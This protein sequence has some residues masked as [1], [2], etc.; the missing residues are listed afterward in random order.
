MS[1]QAAAVRQTGS[2]LLTE[3]DE[4]AVNLD[5]WQR[6]LQRDTEAVIALRQQLDGRTLQRQGFSISH[7][8]VLVTVRELEAAGIIR[9]VQLHL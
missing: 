1:L 2:S 4:V 5:L 9:S 8:E 3:I 6:V 7:T